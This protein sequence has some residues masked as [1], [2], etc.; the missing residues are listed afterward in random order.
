MN[1][2][3]SQASSTSPKSCTSYFGPYDQQ[4]KAEIELKQL[5]MK[6]NHKPTKFFVTFTEFPLCSTTTS[7]SASPPTSNTSPPQFMAPLVSLVKAP[8][9]M[10]AAR[11]AGL[12]VFQLNLASP[13]V[14]N[15]AA[16]SGENIDISESIK[17]HVLE[18]YHEF[19][20]VF[21][22]V[23]ADT[24]ALHWPYDLKINLEEGASPPIGPI[25]SLSA[26]KLKGL[27]RFIDEHLNIGYIW[28]SRSSHGAPVLF[29]RKKDG[30]LRLCIN[31]RGLNKISKKDRYPLPLIADLL[32]APKKAR[33]Y[34][35][36][37][38]HHAF[39]L[40]QVAEGSERKTT[41]RTCYGSFERM[42]MPFGLTNGPAV[43]QHFMNEILADLLDVCMVV[44][45][46]HILIYSNDPS[47][48][49]D[50][51]K[52]VLRRLCQHNLFAHEDKCE[53]HRTSVEFLLD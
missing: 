25:Y 51:I 36:I 41:F 4:A 23:H 35:K 53:F 47:S 15:W 46:D 5:V 18:K 39:H 43:F 30:S 40:V 9:F 22:K 19:A 27:C 37:D 6:D 24:L 3:G 21:S 11:L 26:S 2:D 44:Y 1:L 49:Q 10:Q 14:L 48:H 38:L 34:T 12:R 28:A 31:F 52:E 17:K 33:I 45:L 7:T 20:D 16:T 8:A 50:H 42:V 29:V 32:D 13:E